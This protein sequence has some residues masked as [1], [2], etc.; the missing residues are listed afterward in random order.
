LSELSAPFIGSKKLI[1]AS[2]PVIRFTQL[3]A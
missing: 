3:P 1:P 2:P